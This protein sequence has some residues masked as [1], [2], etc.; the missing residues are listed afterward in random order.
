MARRQL[1]FSFVR[2]PRLGCIA[3]SVLCAGLA[4]AASLEERVEALFRPPLADQATLSADGHRVAYTA[5]VGGKTAIVM[6]LLEPLGPRR[7]VPL[8]PDS[9]PPATAGAFPPPRAGSSPSLRFL[10]WSGPNRLV[11]APVEQVAPL[12]P[13]PD[14]AGVAR[15]N[16]DGPA[17]HAP[18]YVVDAD[19][20]NRGT[21]VDARQFLE[22]P[23]EARQSLADLLKTADQ[24]AAARPAAP[25][26]GGWRMPHVDILGFHPREPD[27]L[28]IATRGAYS[29]PAQHLVDLRTANIREFGG[30]WPAPPAPPQV[31][32]W[33][34]LK[35][36]GE[37]RTT[38]PPSTQ[39]HDAELARL[40]RELE[41][42]FPR[43]TVDLLDWSD[44]RSR[45]L[46]RVSGGAD[47]GRLFVL[48]RPEETVLELTRLAPWLKSGAGH[49]TRH[50]AFNAPDG[51]A[52]SGYLTWPTQPRAARPPL[53]V[54]FPD[55]LSHPIQPAWDPVAQLFADFGFAVVRLSARLDSATASAAV[56]RRTASEADAVLAWLAD[57][58]P[59]SRTFDPRRVAAFG[60]GLGGYLAVRVAQLRPGTFR[61]AAALAA[62]HDPA[63]W[64]ATLPA[65]DRT[66][67]SPAAAV[68]AAFASAPSLAP[69]VPPPDRI[70]LPVL[71]LGDIPDHRALGLD[72]VTPR[73]VT[74]A[75]GASVE[76]APLDPAF[77][78]GQPAALAATYRRVD[79]FLTA[80][81]PPFDV[82][83]GVAREVP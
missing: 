33:F 28:I 13:V 1:S 47:P 17:V 5:T 50:F 37:R 69:A 27:Q 61:A 11:F 14:A 42:R 53:L 81:L 2:S 56:D 26:A 21:V 22:T 63:T 4:P 23:D 64:L 76:R 68:R 71:L 74:F 32:D 40:Q 45:V 73:D 24:L 78:T 49:D 34:R 36:V 44:H 25:R 46:F 3:A 52:I 38:C 6:Q 30:D 16:P 18:V 83:V 31:F 43:R 72:G 59:A 41:A 66:P 35:T 20:R 60:R 77:N 80:H 9:P 7:T 62:P 67:R 51:A 75:L 15:P 19:G 10:R 79:A 54:V 58:R 82:K 48:Q 12:P 29:L 55:A 70:P 57:T 65:T 8:E 39:W